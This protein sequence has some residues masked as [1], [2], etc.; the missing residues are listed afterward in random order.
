[1]S[2]VG[3]K[4]KIG[5]TLIER[6]LR[7]AKEYPNNTAVH[8]NGRTVNY[9]DLKRLAMNYAQSINDLGVRRLVVCLPRGIE[10]IAVLL[11]CQ[12]RNVPYIPVDTSSGLERVLKII[13]NTEAHALV[14]EKT[15][16][17]ISVRRL[18]VGIFGLDALQST[19]EGIG[20]FDTALARQPDSTD[21]YWIYTSGSTG[22]PKCVMVG[23]K[24]CGNLID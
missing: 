19:S 2:L 21:S 14:S 24:G 8:F 13:E 6:F 4:R 23:E 12:L 22:D 7:A 11:A 3:E 1:M 9:S 18:D 17:Q 20:S 16:A 10:T 5:P 15:Y